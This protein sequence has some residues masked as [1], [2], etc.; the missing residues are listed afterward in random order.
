MLQFGGVAA[1][2]LFYLAWPGWLS[3][4]NQL[5]YVQLGI[6]LHLLVAFL[7]FTRS[8]QLNGFWQY[9]RALFER[10]LT[11]FLFSFVLYVGLT[12]ALVAVG[13]LFG[14]GM[15]DA[16][17]LQLW[18]LV[19]FG[20]NTWFFLAGIPTDLDGLESE[21]D[22]PVGLKV[23]AQY[24]LVPLVTIYV[25]ILTAY[26][27]KIIITTEWPSGWIGYLVSSVAVL[28]IFSL[29]LVQPI[30]EK[31]ENRWI[32][33]YARWFY[34]A[35]L[36]SVIM[37]LLAIWQRVNQYGFTEKRYF[38]TVLGL[39]LAAIAVYYTVKRS[40]NIRIIPISLCAIAFVTSVGPWGAYGVSR[41]SQVN[42]LEGLLTGNQ[43]L[44]DG[45]VRPASEPVSFEDRRE[46]SAGFRY[47]LQTHGSRSVEGWFGGEWADIDT[48]GD[49]EMCRF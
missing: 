46:I 49:T 44:V 9:N 21:T 3:E 39:W 32:G 33:T 34:I 17:Y 48:I 7:P 29:L 36:P 24:V 22:Y 13:I 43:V 35:L 4:V 28:G 47:L 26:L 45:V 1:L 16:I 42:R 12:L 27:G 14:V 20:F 10:F 23:F 25:A 37:L 19:A 18:V 11:A 2:V 41:R 5:R 40:S 8:T 38:L 15:P 30:R 31:T 6:G